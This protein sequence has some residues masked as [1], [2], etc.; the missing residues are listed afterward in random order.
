MPHV[1]ADIHLTPIGTGTTSLSD[2][3]AAAEVVLKPFSNLKTRLNP[4]STTLEG[5]LEEVL[6]AVRL[7][8]EAPFTKGACRV[9]TT[10]RIDDRRDTP[11]TM[12]QRIQSVESKL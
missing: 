12:A 10:L 7:M 5:D 4:M 3:I 8:H 11:S 1:I 6:L 9:S 2:Y